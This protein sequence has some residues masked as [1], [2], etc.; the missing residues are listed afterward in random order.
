MKPSAKF[1]ISALILLAA[2]AA[3][4]FGYNLVSQKSAALALTE[5]QIQLQT[6]AATRAASSRSLLN[7]ISGDET[8]IQ[9]YFVANSQVVSFIDD[10]QHRGAA[11]GTAVEITS[12]NSSSA[13]RSALSI[14]L[15][16]KG[17]FAAVMRTI[18]AIEYAPYDIT[19]SALSLTQ[20]DKSSWVATMTIVVGSAP[21][22]AS[23][24]PTTP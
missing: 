12:V 19:V 15:T 6:Q 2:L 20:G 13:G 22:V 21:D 8:A 4:G 16:I 24:T 11:Q 17:S 14:A 5:A 3:Y 1:G 23:T 7:A 10:L 9:Q 18:G